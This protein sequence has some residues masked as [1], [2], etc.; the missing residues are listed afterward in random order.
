MGP[1]INCCEK[2]CYPKKNTLRIMNFQV[3]DSHSVP[4]FKNP[5]KYPIHPNILKLEEKNT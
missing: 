2:N 1:Q 3:R 5:T 4:L